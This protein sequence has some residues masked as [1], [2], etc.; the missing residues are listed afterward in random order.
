MEAVA[1]EERIRQ[2]EVVARGAGQGGVVLLAGAEVTGV[3]WTQSAQEG[4]LRQSAL[5]RLSGRRLRR[6]RP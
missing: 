4:S 5:L 2:P 6:T 3:A 1:L